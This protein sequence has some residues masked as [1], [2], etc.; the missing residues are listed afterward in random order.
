VN[1][2]IQELRDAS[3]LWGEPVFK[4]QELLKTDAGDEN[5]QVAVIG[6][7]GERLVRFSAI[8]VGCRALGRG[9]LGA[10]LGSKLF[11]G[12]AVRGS[13]RLEVDDMEATLQKTQDL[14]KNYAGSSFN[15]AGSSSI[16]YPGSGECE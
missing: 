7:A 15:R 16:W 1:N 9:G 4:A 2:T 5:V 12:I 10:V 3:H 14:F 6:P 11:K 8:L 13:G